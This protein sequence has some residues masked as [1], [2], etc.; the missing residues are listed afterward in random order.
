MSS[1]WAIANLR[2][3]DPVRDCRDG[4]EVRDEVRDEEARG[5]A[6]VHCILDVLEGP[7]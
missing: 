3:G 1:N 4:D 2:V 6:G 7:F 5:T